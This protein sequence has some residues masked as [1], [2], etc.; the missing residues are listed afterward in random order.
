MLFLFSFFIYS[1]FSYSSLTVAIFCLILLF[2]YTVTTTLLLCIPYFDVTFTL[3]HLLLTFVDCW[4][5]YRLL[6]LSLLVFVVYLYD[7]QY[8]CCCCCCWAV[9]DVSIP[10][11]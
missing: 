5:R 8:I 6:I 1:V 7:I 4:P 3:L 11:I 10:I 2:V 9:D